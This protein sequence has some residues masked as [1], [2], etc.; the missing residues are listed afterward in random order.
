MCDC[1]CELPKREKWAQ[2]K[3]MYAREIAEEIRASKV[4]EPL[5]EAEEHVNYVL[6]DLANRIDP[7]KEGQ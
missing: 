1:D 5:G 3:S 4:A 2:I 6:D 7:K